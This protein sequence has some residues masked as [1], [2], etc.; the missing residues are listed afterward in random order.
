MVVLAGDMNGHVG[1]S[2]AMMG[3][4]VVL[5]MET[6]MQWFQHRICRRAK[7]SHLQH[8][9]HEAGIPVGDICS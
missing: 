3:R 5:G 1:S 7:L 6:G 8:I 4:M 9:V 2:N